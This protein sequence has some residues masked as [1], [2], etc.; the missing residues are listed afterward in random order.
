MKELFKDVIFVIPARRGSKGLPLKNREL[1]KYTLDIIPPE[2]RSQVVVSSDDEYIIKEARSRRFLV[3]IRPS[4]FAQDNTSMLDVMKYINTYTYNAHFKTIILLYLT[5]PER[6]WKDVIDAYNFY[7]LYGGK[8]LLCKKEPDV[9]PYLMMHERNK[10]YGEQIIKHDLYRRQD[11]P[12]TFEISHYISIFNKREIH[13]LNNNLYNERTIFFPIGNVVDID[14]KKDLEKFEKHEKN[15]ETKINIDRKNIKINILTR[16]SGRP[17][18]FK[19]CRESILSQTHKNIKHLISSDSKNNTYLKGIEYIDVKPIKIED[20]KLKKGE[21]FAPY[22][23]YLNDLL[24]EVKDGWVLILDDDDAFVSEDSLSEIVSHIN[25][26]DDL[27]F[28]RV[29]FP[30]QLIPSDKYWMKEPQE[31]QISMIGFMFHSKWINNFKFDYLTKGDYRVIKTLWNLIPNKIWIDK[32]LTKLQRDIGMGGHGTKDDIDVKYDIII[33]S[34]NMSKVTIECLRSI[35]RYS[36]SYRIIFIDN[37]SDKN[38]FDKIYKILKDIPHI[39]IQNK[40][41]LGFVKAVNQGIKYSIDSGL[42]EYIILMNNDT[43]A[44]DG[45]L[46][47]LTQPFLEHQNIGA[48][49]P[50]TTTPNSWQG[51]YPKNR[52]GYVIKKNGMLAFFCT[53]IKKDVFL[54]IGLLDETFGIGFGD[55][56]DYCKRML[57]NGYVLALV[58]DLIIPHHHRT[59][60]NHLYGDEKIKKMQEKAIIHFKNKHKI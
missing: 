42:S 24:Q 56:D 22:N 60:F 26:E 4:E 8:S 58:Q 15:Q 1:L 46:E 6:T 25:S 39:L 43:E 27:L 7:K 31:C 52:T 17:L 29:Q 47:K 10:I 23:L 30:N 48:V 55:D 20:V 40:E 5:Y 37:A 41:N 21:T 16:T 49:G 9:S 51:K 32:I 12:E 34:W 50:L 3:N 57:D 54:N 13:Y 18:Y 59:T 19:K 14:T 53:M 28:W 45:W 11:Y 36:S 35:K 33:P 38:E 44:V 2:L